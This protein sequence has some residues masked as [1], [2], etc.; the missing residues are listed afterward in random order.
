[1]LLLRPE[2]Q[3]AASQII[4][5]VFHETHRPSSTFSEPLFN[6]L[7]SFPHFFDLCRS[8][9]S[10]G[11]RDLRHSARPFYQKINIPNYQVALD[12]LSRR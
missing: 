3:S 9:N 1:M 6:R 12:C 2:Q 10:P 8:S 4:E 11:L 7:Q 5:V